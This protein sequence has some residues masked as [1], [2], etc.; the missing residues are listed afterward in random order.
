[1][2]EFL[3]RL[4]G[5]LVN[6]VKEEIKEIKSLVVTEEDRKQ[7]KKLAVLAVASLT[8]MGVPISALGTEVIAVAMAYGV[9]DLKDGLETHDKLIISRIIK[10]IKEGGKSSSAL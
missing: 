6:P 5:I 10:E 4:K 9:R 1:M 8:A 7:G 2:K 3:R